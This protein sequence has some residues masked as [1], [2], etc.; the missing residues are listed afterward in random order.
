MLDGLYKGASALDMLTRQQETVAANIAHLNTPGY[1]RAVFSFAQTSDTQHTGQSAAKPSID[2]NDGRLEATGRKLDL[3][4][5][6]DGFFVFE[7]QGG[8]LY[9]RN[10]VLALNPET[11][12]LVNMDGLPILGEGGPI[13]VEG[14]PSQ[15]TVGADGKISLGQE[16]IGRLSI[17]QFDNNKL[18]DTDG[19]I[20]FRAGAAQIVPTE[21]IQVHQGFR[22]LSNAHPMT[23]MISLIVGSRH[24]EASQRAMRMISDTMQEATSKS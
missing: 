15:L 20:Y 11:K 19:Q 8:K 9:S 21:D 13:T 16:E 22:E 7:S 17:V 18:L 12:Q 4:L 14:D 1:R 2:F 5:R 23:E 3:A 24:F 10:G 6:G